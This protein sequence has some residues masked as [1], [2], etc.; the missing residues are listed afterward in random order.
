[1][2]ISAGPLL[3]FLW[4][5]LMLAG[6][7]GALFIPPLLDL[8]VALIWGFGAI[9]RMTS[10]VGQGARGRNCCARASIIE[11]REFRNLDGCG[12]FAIC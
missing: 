12:Q 2:Q 3:L 1:M 9:P 8:L 6:P 5:R 7:R 4:A 11:F 10:R